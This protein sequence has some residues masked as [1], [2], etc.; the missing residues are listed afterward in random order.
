MSPEM[1]LPTSIS[2]IIP[3]YNE[4][5]QITSK[6]ANIERSTRE[7]IVIADGGSQD[8][9]RVIGSSFGARVIVSSR[10]RA[11]QMNAGAAAA[12]GEILVFLHADTHLP[13]GYHGY[14]RE[15]M[16]RPGTVAGAFKLRFEGRTTP[17]LRFIE[18]TANWRSKFLQ[19]PF[20][21]QG[22][23]LQR[24]LFAEV[25]GFREIP[26]MEDL[27]LIRRLKP[28]GRITIVPAYVTT[29]GRRYE[30][31][32]TLRRTLIN[33]ASITSYYLGLS[34]WRIARWYDRG[35]SSTNK[36]EGPGDVGDNTRKFEK[37]HINT[38]RATAWE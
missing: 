37:K 12:K 28:R 35:G 21:D 33:K 29:S 2:I 7:E 38:R 17:L 22:I 24:A 8:D 31:L 11:T 34:P 26:I 6:L 13:K 27:E 30:A 15:A 1:P 14:I 23:F 10:G 25:G 5:A 3:T 4:A 16:C 36:R 20:G 9:T 32:G 19:I 18:Y